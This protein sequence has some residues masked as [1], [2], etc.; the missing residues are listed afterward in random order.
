[1]SKRRE[2]DDDVL[3]QA[4]H[5]EVKQEIKECKGEEYGKPEARRKGISIEKFVSSTLE[6]MYPKV[7]KQG[8]MEFRL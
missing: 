2:G 1:M 3:Q 6:N 5:D 8:G 7:G 4:H